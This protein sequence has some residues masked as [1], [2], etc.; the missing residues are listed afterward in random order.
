[1]IKKILLNSLFVLLV[2]TPVLAKDSDI[3]DRQSRKIIVDRVCRLRSSNRY[4][5]REIFNLTRGFVFDNANLTSLPQVSSDDKI[6]ASI[7]QTSTVLF[8]RVQLCSINGFSLGSPER[9]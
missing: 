1:M 6:L 8:L 3:L 4:T 2:T 9:S 7:Q 5:E